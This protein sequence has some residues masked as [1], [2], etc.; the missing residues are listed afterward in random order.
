MMG[1]EHATKHATQTDRER[2]FRSQTMIAEC[3]LRPSRHATDESSTAASSF[4]SSSS[5]TASSSCS[6][7]PP[8]FDL[9]LVY[10]ELSRFTLDASSCLPDLVL[11][12][13]LLGATMVHGDNKWATV[14][15]LKYFTSG[16]HMWKVKLDRCTGGNT[17]LGVCNATMKL[18]NYIGHDANGWGYYGCGNTYRL[19]SSS[20]YGQSYRTGDTI[21]VRLD[22]DK[23]TLSFDKNDAPLGV[24][25]T[26]LPDLVYPAFS[27][28]SKNDHMQ[29]IE[30]GTF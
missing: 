28:Y 30:F 9:L 14:R 13:D 12:P 6:P 17:F 15:A 4:S 2:F 20:S 22:M 1:G 8:L 26:D 25:F 19:G 5:S 10:D 7:L 16:R 23:K 24:A 21:T 18:N 27:L 3:G 11:T 29:I